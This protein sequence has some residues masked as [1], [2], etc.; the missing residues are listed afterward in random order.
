[1]MRHYS[2]QIADFK[3]PPVAQKT[4]DNPYDQTP[5]ASIDTTDWQG[6][7][8]ALSVAKKTFQSREQWLSIPQRLDILKK[9]CELMRQQEDQLALQIAEEGGKPLSDAIIETNRAIDGVELA[10]MTLRQQKGTVI[11]MQVNA[12]SSYRNAFTVLEPAGVVLAFSAFNHPLNLIVHQVIPAVATGCPFIIKPAEA[13]PI[14]CINLINILRQAGLPESW[15]QVIHC[16]HETSTKMVSDPRISFFSFIGSA[17]IGWMLRSYLPDGAHCTLEHGGSAPV[18]ITEG[19]DW[20]NIIPQLLKGGFYHAGQVCVSVQ[21]IFAHKNI[22]RELALTMANQAKQLRIGPATELDTDIG[23]LIRH[24]EVERIHEWV[25]EAHTNGAEILC[26]GKPFSDNCYLPTVLYNPCESCKVSCNEVFGPVVS[27]YPYANFD[28]AI[29]QSNHPDFA[30]Q[31][32]IF[33]HDLNLAMKA[34]NKLV[35]KTVL[36]NDHSA[37]RVDWMPFGGFKKSGLGTGGIGYSMHD[38]QIEKMIVI[39]SDYNNS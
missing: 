11:P 14:S 5:I 4:V 13:T 28:D 2:L 27:I 24:R 34:A 16:N 1:M 12:A 19:F 17:D 29:E 30:F 35:A 39:H 9:T 21:R 33:T 15:G 23:P 38:M 26:G 20:N 6:A 31:S 18:I 7:D 8:H 37:F 32:S 22:A 3:K 25:Q 10:I 36:I